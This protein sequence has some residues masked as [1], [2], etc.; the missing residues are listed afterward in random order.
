M[1]VIL[2]H[3]LNSSFSGRGIYVQKCGVEVWGSDI[4]K[5]MMVDSFSPPFLRVRVPGS[6]FVFE[7][8]EKAGSF[9][10]STTTFI[11]HEPIAVLVRFEEQFGP[12]CWMNE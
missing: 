5:Q 8:A 10:T 9:M 1:P 11:Q 4:G 6:G 3:I 7:L 2:R 12:V